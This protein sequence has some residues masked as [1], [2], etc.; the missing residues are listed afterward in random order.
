MGTALI[1]LVAAGMAGEVARLLIQA[2]WLPA[3]EALW[4]T[5]GWLPE[6]SVPG[7]ILYA[8]IGYEAT[9]S[10]LQAAFYFGGLLLLLALVTVSRL[11]MRSGTDE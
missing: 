11:W 8:L 5:S 10:P 4:D 3:Q 9:P 7:Q 2:D 1:A 6:D